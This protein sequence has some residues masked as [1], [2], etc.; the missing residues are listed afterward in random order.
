MSKARVTLS[1]DETLLGAL[2]A[3]VQ[4]ELAESRSAAV[5][6][7]LRLWQLERQRRQLER[8]VE[9]YYRTQSRKEREEDRAWA[10][11]TSRHARRLWEES[12]A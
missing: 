2:D 3:A 8:E 6:D 5:E 9:A 4:H 1:L 11:L 12:P 10:R 7:A